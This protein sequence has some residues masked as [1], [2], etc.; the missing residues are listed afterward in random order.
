MNN[1]TIEIMR[2]RLQRGAWRR[3]AVGIGGRP[4]DVGPDSETEAL[5]R[6]A[7]MGITSHAQLKNL[8]RRNEHETA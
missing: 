4:N 2:E 6:D 3:V 5:Q 1:I 8:I 7:L